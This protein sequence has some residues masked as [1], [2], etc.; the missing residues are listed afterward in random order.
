M[1]SGS[2]RAVIY[3]SMQFKTFYPCLAVGILFLGF[4]AACRG[5]AEPTGSGTLEI[6]GPASV[7]P[8]Q[9]ARYAVVEHRP[10][11][12]TRPVSDIRWTSTE[13]SVL[14]VDGLGLATAG[15]RGET[16]LHADVPSSGRRATRE[17][18]VLPSGTYRLVGTVLEAGGGGAPIAGAGIEVRTD[19]GVVTPPLLHA[20][21][22]VDGRYRLYGVP[23]DGYVR[24]AIDGYSPIIE[25]VTLATHGM[26]NFELASTSRAGNFAGNYTLIIGA[27]A[28]CSSAPQPLAAELRRRTFGVTVRQEG[29][30]LTVAVGSNCVA[31]IYG[32]CQ[33]LGQASPSGA[34][35][36]I[37]DGGSSFYT[38]PDL[39]EKISGDG[40]TGLVVIGRVAA[41]RSG[42]GLSGNMT[43]SLT[44][45]NVISPYPREP[46]GQCPAGRFELVPR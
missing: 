9:S 34:A 32:G 37:T 46:L 21:T 38:Y 35:F 41:V 5:P 16:V 44:H 14:Q 31:G 18:V 20:S 27:D 36:D 22:A 11:G 25:H 29:S 3:G 10:G 8:G 40:I 30:R 1:L 39:V 43:G 45:Y 4:G 33:F 19:D 17:I 12:S 6:T 42:A 13:T 24:V 23:G 28:A 26:R 15:S 2:C 7:A